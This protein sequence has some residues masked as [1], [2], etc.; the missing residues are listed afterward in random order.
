[1]KSLSFVV[2]TFAVSSLFAGWNLSPFSGWRV[3]G[4]VNYNSNL[5]TEL[6]VSGGR[7]LPYMVSPVRPDGVSKAEAE[8]VL[9][10]IGSGQ[11]V[12]FSKGAFI[13]PDYAG[14]GMMPDYTWN[15][16]A[17]AGS[18]SGG[19]MNFSYDYVEVT[20]VDVGNL[21]HSSKDES[22]IPGFTVEIQRNLGSWGRFGLDM[23][24]GFNYFKKND[25]YK[26][27]GEIYRRIDTVENG[28]YITSVEMD[29]AMADWAQ[30]PDGSYGSG[31]YDGPGAMLPLLLGG[32]SAFSFSSK[33]NSISTT[34]HSMYLNSSADYEEIELTVTAKPYYDITDY[35][36][37]VGTLGVVVSRGALDF[38]IAASSDSRRL[39]SDSESFH[40]WDCYGIGGLGGMFHYGH[41]SL[42]FDFL[43]RF[44]D[45]DV[46][47]DGR[48]VSGSIERS[49][50]MFRVY[51][52]FEF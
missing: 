39:Y 9:Q 32:Q 41:I 8:M 34:T 46:E 43:A 22:D 52:G 31:T 18:Y 21:A 17:P 6:N 28:A 45:S 14:K 7:A 33:V 40:K 42:G 2:A 51:A 20:S 29:Q 47:I 35:F 25:V 37:V 49:P 38:D 48:N 50:W 26:S 36:R 1:M 10:A 19:A 13:D 30:N 23:G 3:I 24:L 44:F 27:S 16:Y 4:G 12:D 11:R 15:W 5:K